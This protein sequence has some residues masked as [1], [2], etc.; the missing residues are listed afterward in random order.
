MALADPLLDGLDI[1]Q[2]VELRWSRYGLGETLGTTMLVIEMTEDMIEQR[3][4]LLL[5]GS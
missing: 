2:E 3:A 4:D 1:D 5:W